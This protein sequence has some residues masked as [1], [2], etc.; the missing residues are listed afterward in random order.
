MRLTCFSHSTSFSAFASP[1]L[2]RPPNPRALAAVL[3]HVVRYWVHSNHSGQFAV[4][5]HGLATFMRLLTTFKNALYA[6]AA[7]ASSPMTS[8]GASAASPGLRCAAL[9]NSGGRDTARD[10]ADL[11]VAR[12]RFSKLCSAD[13]TAVEVKRQRNNANHHAR[14]TRQRQR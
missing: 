7:A 5:D 9:R 1:A 6:P 11:S 3:N 4:G 12:K 10:L 2:R 8:Q 13:V 14:S